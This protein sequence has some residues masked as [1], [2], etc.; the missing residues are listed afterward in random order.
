[1]QQP[2]VSI[3]MPVYNGLPLIKASVESL[4][5][6]TYPNWECVIVD[7]G[8]TDG[9][10]EYLDTLNDERFVVH[11]QPNGGRPAARQKALELA[12]GKYIAMLD[13]EDL[14]HPDKLSL[15]VKALEDNPDI[16]L[17]G[18]MMCSFGTKTN[19]LFVRGY[20]NETVIQFDGKKTPCHA[21]SLLRA[22]IAK[23]L[24][25]NPSM[26]LGEDVDFLEKY[27]C[28]RKYTVLNRVLYY[29]SELDSVSK[30][31]IRR[32]Y[33]LYIGKYWQQRRYKT[34]FV[35]LLK[36]IYSIFVFPFHSIDTILSKRGSFATSEERDTFEK[37]C[38]PLV[39]KYEI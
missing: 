3:T 13:A 18:T 22:E 31:K 9:T 6:Q 26:K 7:D 15:Q 27:L 29:Y 28:G 35:Y 20:S 14:H 30:K 8:S 37:N 33:Y 16:S 1:M 39:Q 10:S 25:Y 11:H 23:P 12:R 4:L 34:S 19:K 17:V 21:T 2:L 24:R 5:G 32:N 38:L 36:Y